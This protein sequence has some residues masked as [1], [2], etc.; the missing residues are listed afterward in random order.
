MKI[1]GLRFKNLNSLYGEWTIDFTSPEYISD[2]IFVLTGP[3]GSGKSTILDA[4]S[5]A[6]YGTTP[7]LG[8]IS[9]SSNEVMSRNTGECY[10]ELIFE[11]QAGKFR[12]H[13]SQHRARKDPTRNLIDSKQ[14][15]SD[16]RTGQVLGSKKTDVSVIIE[17]KTGMD[18]KRF[19]RSILL[20]QGEFDTF[21]KASPEDK[22]MI[23]EQITGTEIYTEIS[24]KVHEKRR[25]EK[26][27]LEILQAQVSGIHPLSEEEEEKTKHDLKIKKESKTKRQ[28][29]LEEFKT[30]IQWRNKINEIQDKIQNLSKENK[31]L[32]IEIESFKPKEG[33]LESA[34]KATKLKGDY[35]KLCEIRKQQNRDQSVI[36]TKKKECDDKTKEE[37]QG[38]NE[39]E[40]SENK[41]IECK[42]EQ[43]SL[44]PKTR[45]TRLLDQQ[46]YERKRSIDHLQ[47][48][49]KN[50]DQK[51]TKNKKEAKQKKE[52][53]NN[54]QKKIE[55][56][57]NYLQTNTQDELLIQQ[58]P[59]I[60]EQF[61][62]ILPMEKDI[63][64]KT[65]SVK[66]NKKELNDTLE[67]ISDNDKLLNSY[68]DKRKQVT[69]QIELEK[70]QLNDLLKDQSLNDYRK[71]KD[72]LWQQMISLKKITDLK[73]ERSNLKDGQPCPLCGSK[74]HPYVNKS[75]LPDKDETEK[76]IDQFA[77]LIKK[78]EDHEIKIKEYEKSK[79]QYLSEY[80]SIEKKKI[81]Y[82]TQKENYE[83]ELRKLQQ[84]M[85][86]QNENFEKLKEEISNKLKPFDIQEASK[87]NIDLLE[88]RC[89]KWQEQKQCEEKIKEQ[90]T[91]LEV[92]LNSLEAII[93]NDNP[94]LVGK[95]EEIINLK[96]EY[97]G[98]IIKRQDLFADKD[99]DK[100][101]ERL[102]EV[103]LKAEEDKENIQKKYNEIQKNLYSI[104]DHI[105][106]L[107]DQ[108]LQ[109]SSQL[110]ALEVTFK[111]CL[112]SSGFINEQNFKECLLSDEEQSQLT[113][114][115][116]QLNDKKTSITARKNE[117][118]KALAEEMNKKTTHLTIEDLKLSQT[119]L[120]EDLETITNDIA[121]LEYKFKDNEQSKKRFKERKILIKKQKKEYSRWEKLGDLIASS[122]GKKYRNFA[123]GLTFN[124]MISHANKQLKKITDRYLLIHD[125]KK[126]L[127]LNVVDNYQAGEIRPIKNLSG[128]ESFIVSLAL[129]LGL[130]K[131]ASHKVRVDSLF[132]DEGFGTLDE[133]T[134]ETAMEALASLQQ[135]GKL[136]G[137]ISHISTL[138]E[139]ISTQIHITPTSGGRSLIKGPGVQKI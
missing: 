22:S 116:N 17:E 36:K 108:I 128:G 122:D 24:K 79:E 111:D 60:K 92:N 115:M 127:E 42:K 83:N 124:L 129:A 58:L 68:K 53:I 9:Q 125:N 50:F 103:V 18:F 121:A 82:M 86:D 84:E 100:E 35:S 120:N 97:K 40:A 11:S 77:Q 48:D 98:Q 112:K 28:N 134:L 81:Q 39:L 56:I 87:E 65:N 30:A 3:T 135:D 70:N 132:L 15:I 99:P 29:E 32:D 75:S 88:D 61:K 46:I 93:R 80:N 107:D 96:K 13:W 136:I 8:K 10:A 49:Y 12:C 104:K 118:E 114:K 133:D 74:D 16:I 14:E 78:A 41:I 95:K 31:V 67:N 25:N 27:Q 89:K 59:V 138:K 51:I 109:R 4:I 106:L 5:L 113:D 126:P 1:L 119:K 91:N 2:G 76:K 69:Q 105:K 90:K 64:K 23:L 52:E 19:T 44:I 73:S 34:Q 62:S 21:L 54:V 38:K 26:N 101:E 139:R 57:Q 6:L 110:Q 85:S 130:S 137:V 123:Q 47:A 94:L 102:N 131:M 43:T 117:Q 66:K 33:K 45:E 37:S 7:R 63:F 71:E 72:Q 20:A 55:D